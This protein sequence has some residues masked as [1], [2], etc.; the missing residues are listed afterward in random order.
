MRLWGASNR[1]IKLVSSGKLKV[2][3]DADVSDSLP[4]RKPLSPIP[5]DPHR[6]RSKGWYANIAKEL[7]RLDALMNGD[8][9]ST[10]GLI[11]KLPEALELPPEVIAEAIEQ[12]RRQI[13]EREERAFRAALNPMRS[14]S[15]KHDPSSDM[16]TSGFIGSMAWSRSSARPSAG[17]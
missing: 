6:S 7:R 8:F 1:E 2:I 11:A 4:R 14:S 9:D 17:S 13:H 10:K 12:T 15:L 16:P 5:S 3:Q